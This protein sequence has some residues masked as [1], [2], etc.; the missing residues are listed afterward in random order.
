MPHTVVYY[1]D[2]NNF[3]GAEQVLYTILNELDRNEW[4]PILAYH[5]STGIMPFI[6][7]V[8][9]LKVETLSVPEIRSYLDIS[10]I[11]QFA[12][13]LRAIRPAIFHANINWPLS[14][15]YGIIAA[16]LARIRAIVATQHLYEEIYSRRDR[17]MQR[18]ISYLVD[19]YIAISSD[20]AKHLKKAISSEKKVKVVQNGIDLEYYSGGANNHSNRGV[21][22]PFNKNSL[23]VIL[24]VARLAK[25][26]GHTYLLK[27]ATRIPGALFVFVGDGPE[28]LNLENEARELN[29]TDR[30]IFLGERNDIPSLLSNCDLF[31][32][33]SLFEGGLAL[34]IMEAMAVCKPVITTDVEGV[35]KNLINGEDALIVPPADSE[36]L[37]D[38]IKTLL[39]N[40]E[41][42]NRIARS[43]KSLVYKEF[44]AGRMVKEIIL[45]YDEFL[46]NRQKY[47]QA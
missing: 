14:C 21:F 16:Y 24:T 25:Q 18:F 34:S 29:M 7:L 42:A 36:V 45:I 23:P 8:E 9:K 12:S 44:S 26:K 31:V 28:R 4:H 1:I 27:A 19:C 3:G 33:P 2:S 22:A 17:I 41:L 43:G 35:S 13:K 10:R 5:P 47:N 39:S 38:A 11:L 20:L 15:S 46:R 40:T 37:A 6:E 32:Q 30:V